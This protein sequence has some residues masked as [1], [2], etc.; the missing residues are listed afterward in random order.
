MFEHKSRP[1]FGSIF[2]KDDQPTRGPWFGAESK[3]DADPP[4][5]TAGSAAAASSMFTGMYDGPTVQRDEAGELDGAPLGA[6]ELVPAGGSRLDAKLRR[7]MEARLGASFAGVRIHEDAGRAGAMKA[8]AYTVGEDIVFAPGKLDAGSEQGR[9]RIAHELAHVVQQRAG[10]VSGRAVGKGVN[11]SEPGDAHERAAHDAADRAMGGAAPAAAPVASSGGGG[12]GAAT[13]QR[14][15]SEEGGIDYWKWAKKGL[16]K[17]VDYGVKKLPE[18]AA[19]TLGSVPGQVV[20]K[21]VGVAKVLSKPAGTHARS[22]EAQKQL[23]DAV[24]V[25]GKLATGAINKR[26]LKGEVKEG[27]EDEIKV[28]GDLNGDGTTI[29]R[30]LQGENVG[31]I[32]NGRTIVKPDGTIIDKATGKEVTG[33]QEPDAG[34]E[35]ESAQ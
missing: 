28:E 23:E 1:A 3:P 21:G 2:D 35:Q 29:N 11:M 17:A 8:N 27:P 26:Y 15:E 22:D 33:P 9:H 30:N 10:A 34:G 12:G 32:D 25:L 7:E 19:K 4:R 16:K 14:D 24:P 31:D 18:E 13:V 6:G 20:D 5:P